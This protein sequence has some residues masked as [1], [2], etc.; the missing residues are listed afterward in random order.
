[1]KRLVISFFI[2]IFFF[3]FFSSTAISARICGETGC[4]EYGCTGVGITCNGGNDTCGSKF[5]QCNGAT[6]TTCQANTGWDTTSPCNTGDECTGSG[7]RTATWTPGTCS[8]NCG[9]SNTRTDTCTCSSNNTCPIQ[10]TAPV[11]PCG[12]TNPVACACVDGPPQAPVITSVTPTCT[13][14]GSTAVNWTFGATTGCGNA[15]GYACSAGSN[16]FYIM[17]GASTIASGIAAGTSPYSRAVTLTAGAHTIKVCADNGPLSNCS[18]VTN[19]NTSI[20]ITAPNAPSGGAVTFA[21]S[22]PSCTDQYVPTY[23]WNAVAADNGCS[24]M[25]ATPYHPQG[26][27]AVGFSPLIW[28]DA[29]QAGTSKT[30]GSSYIPGTT[31]YFQVRSRDAFDTR[32]SFSSPVVT[33]VVP[34][35][36]PYPTI[37]IEGP[38]TEKVSGICYSD[39]TLDKNSFTFAP[40]TNPNTGVTTTCKAKS[41]TR[42]ECDITID[43]SRGLCTV[44]TTTLTLNASYPGYSEAIWRA[45]DA[46]G[47]AGVD[48]TATAGDLVDRSNIPM[49]L[50]YSGGSGTSGWFKLSQTSF[51]SRENGRQNYLPNTMKLFDASGDDSIIGVGKF[52][53]EGTTPG[54]IAQNSPVAVGPASTAYSANNWYTSSYSHTDDITYLK[55]IDYIKAR[56]DFKTITN[57]NLSEITGDGIYSISSS[58]ILSDPT[59]FNGKKVVLVVQ[60]GSA[61]FSTNF[62]PVGGSVVVLAKDIIIDPSVTEIDGILIG[63]T[64]S[65]GVSASGLKIKGNLIDESALQLDRL[66]ADGRMPSLLVVFDIQI[67]V[68]VLPYLSTSTY[69]WRQ[70][71]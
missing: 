21:A 6:N 9:N 15:W 61:T 59:L 64:V 29:W 20:D 35:P 3:A 70:I 7:T 8:T 68:N 58:I 48:I 27:T 69:D 30:A 33:A 23:T 16:T 24:G 54:T 49:F 60:G 62:I 14:N 43:N 12:A 4:A 32:S 41:N 63:Q 36:I 19:V 44:P 40:T 46:C 39:I 65:T 34:S 37:H 56:K 5:N 52:F 18:A 1:M 55:Y 17:D 71:Q 25:N 42:Y 22:N 53:I 10:C 13:T 47:G 26:S 45:G 67:Y 57:T 38:F 2:A 28:A 31:L 66:Q 50:T 51:N 11:R